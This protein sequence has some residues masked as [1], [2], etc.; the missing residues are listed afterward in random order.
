[1]KIL[2][3]SL[4]LA[5]VLFGCKA[6]NN[7]DQ[8]SALQSAADGNP[9][10]G[11]GNTLD[12][13]TIVAAMKKIQAKDSSVSTQSAIEACTRN[14]T[15]HWSYI[16]SHFYCQIGQGR[17]CF[18]GYVRDQSKP[19]FGTT[20]AYRDGFDTCSNDPSFNYIAQDPA[21]ANAFKYVMFT[22]YSPGGINTFTTESQDAAINE[23]YSV[24]SP[25]NC[26]LRFTSSTDSRRSAN[27]RCG[28]FTPAPILPTPGTGGGSPTVG[29]PGG[30]SGGTGG[31]TGGT[32][33]SPAQ[34]N[35]KIECVLHP[36]GNNA[37]LMGYALRVNG[38]FIVHQNG[39]NEMMTNGH[40]LNALN[41]VKNGLICAGRS[42]RGT[43]IKSNGIF[44]LSNQQSVGKFT[45]F[46]G[47]S[48][49]DLCFDSVSKSSPSQVC[50]F[51]F[52]NEYKVVRFDHRS[53]YALETYAGSTTGFNQCLSDIR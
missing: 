19:G 26:N 46:M 10:T 11:T 36:T 35:D 38:N 53:N 45:D 29:T 23:F 5:A 7:V 49:Y 22:V 41:Y 8:G 20:Q 2:L 52:V 13:N 40:C 42:S 1:M 47:S 25:A 32:T 12:V 9:P 39:D 16:V 50:G 17:A 34:G 27:E 48:R 15:P 6:R 21:L 37:Q 51:L 18:S 3:M 28:T 31:A 4:T 33:G 24:T 43:Y 14:D 30:I 44:R